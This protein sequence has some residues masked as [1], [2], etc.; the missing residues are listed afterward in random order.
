VHLIEAVA[1]IAGCEPFRK[2]GGN[3]TPAVQ[4]GADARKVEGI[5]DVELQR[6]GV[7]H[8]SAKIESDLLALR[9]LEKGERIILADQ[10]DRS[11]DVHRRREPIVEW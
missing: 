10:H 7:R 3:G 8:R 11:A 5:E 1:A 9:G 4:P 2:I 6:R